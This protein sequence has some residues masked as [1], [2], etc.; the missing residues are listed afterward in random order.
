MTPRQVFEDSFRIA[1]LLIHIYR[2]LENEGLK[3]EGELVESLRKL[4]ACE[5]DEQLQLIVNAAFVGCIRESADVPS[6][7]L[8]RTSLANLLRQAI[9]SACTAYEVFLS[10]ALQV[11]LP[12]AIMVSRQ[13]AIPPARPSGGDYF[14]ELVIPIREVL[15]LL[16]REDRW[17]AAANKVWNFTKN[18]NLGS[19]DAVDTV[20]SLLGIPDAWSQVCA[21][22]D[23]DAEDLKELLR[24]A[25]KRRNAIVHHGDRDRDSAAFERQPIHYAWTEQVVDTIKHVC[26]AFDEVIGQRMKEHQAELAARKPEDAH[27]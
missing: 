14:R 11:N 2:L 17:E 16:D 6:S 13:N 21:H 15:N 26:L 7:Q 8:K 24:D 1:E 23:R 18:K 20:G 3:T 27:A 10:R 25:L 4:L 5:P 22:L 19:V 9:V 12:V